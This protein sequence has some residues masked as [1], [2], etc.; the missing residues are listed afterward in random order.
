MN[1]SCRIYETTQTN[2]LWPEG[3]TIGGQPGLAALT[4]GEHRSEPLEELYAECHILTNIAHFASICDMWSGD[5]LRSN[6]SAL[7]QTGRRS[8]R[9]PLTIQQS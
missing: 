9:P 7:H 1:G 8:F 6:Y 5:A 4:A 3:G 2:W